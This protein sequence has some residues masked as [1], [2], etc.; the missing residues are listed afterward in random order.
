MEKQ[1]LGLMYTIA[2]DPSYHRVLGRNTRSAEK[3]IFKVPS[4]IRPIYEWSPYYIGTKLLNYL[5]RDV[6]KRRIFLYL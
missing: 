4:K 5:E 3:I 1:L 2:K 6:Q